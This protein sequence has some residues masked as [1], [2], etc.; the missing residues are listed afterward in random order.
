MGYTTIVRN[1]IIINTQQRAK[2]QNGTGYGVINYLT[3]THT[4]VLE[5]NCLYNNKAGDY[6]NAGSTTDIHADP[7]FADQKNHDYHLKSTGGRWNGKTWV[8]DLISSPCIDAG[9][10]SSDYSKEPGDNGGR[11][12]IGRYGNTEYASIS[13][14]M[15][16]YI[17]WWNQILSPEWKIFRLLLRI[18]FLFCLNMTC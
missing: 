15:P 5:N 12:N 4:F 3:G 9:Y 13:G 8:K 16:G 1:N 2:D 14:T 17:V 10:P 7:L 11:V 6:R 18:F